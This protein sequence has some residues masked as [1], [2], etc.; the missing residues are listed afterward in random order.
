MIDV[1]ISQSHS[2]TEEQGRRIVQAW[3]EEWL[4]ISSSDLRPGV[5]EVAT[6]A[7]KLRERLIEFE[8]A[9]S[10]DHGK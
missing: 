1:K 3:I 4:D 7:R 2:V 10:G 9:N 5:S 6:A 8:R